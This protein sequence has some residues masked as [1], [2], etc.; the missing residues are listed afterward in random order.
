MLRCDACMGI[1]GFVVQVVVQ[2]VVTAAAT[3]GA[4]LLGGWLTLRA[5]D[6]LW[7]RDR[8]RQW[9]DIRLERKLEFLGAFREYVAALQSPD[10]RI[11][12][13]PRQ[14]PPHDLMPLF[15]EPGLTQR[16]D[17]TKTAVRLVSASPQVV[18][19][20]RRMVRLARAVAVARSRMAAADIPAQR[21][22][23]LWAAERDFLRLARGE[24]GLPGEFDTDDGGNRRPAGEG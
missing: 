18:E 22:D 21:F 1:L 13:V 16:L 10:V 12:A 11:R 4:V 9:R 20:S 15:D 6:R 24:L 8:A 5:Q 7:E 14:R 19:A 23:E 2:V 17:S 3:L